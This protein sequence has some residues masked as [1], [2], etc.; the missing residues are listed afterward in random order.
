M[1]QFERSCR[2]FVKRHGEALFIA[3][4]LL[5]DCFLS[6]WALTVGTV[7]A[8][9]YVIIP[10]IRTLTT[11]DA[12]A[13]LTFL[14]AFVKTPKFQ[15]LAILLFWIYSIRALIAMA[16]DSALF[17]LGSEQTP[18]LTNALFLGAQQ[19]API[20]FLSS[21]VFV[22]A[23]AC[24]AAI[25]W[26]S[27][28][29]ATKEDPD[30]IRQR[31]VWSGVVQSGFF[32]SY[33]GS[34]LMISLNEKGP[35]FM[36][37]NWLLASARD[38]NLY[39]TV[40]ATPPGIEDPS[41]ITAGPGLM[42]VDIANKFGDLSFISSFDFLLITAFS[43][44]IFL[45]FLQPMLRLTSFMTSFCW[46]VVSPGSLQ[47]IVEGFLEA[48][49]LKERVLGFNEKRVFWGNAL[50]T[51]GWLVACYAGLFWLFGF[52]GGPLGL[53]IQNWM[54]ASGVDA[55]FLNDD[56][57]AKFLFDKNYRIFLG[58]IVA[59]Y[60]TAPLAVTAS[61]ILPYAKARKIT[62]N[63]DGISFFQGPY[64]SLWGRQTRLWSD[65]KS[66]KSV[67]SKT[68]QS[69]SNTAFSL[70]FRS[71][72]Q[73]KFDSSQIPAQDLR[74]L[75]DAI[76]QHA[77]ACTVDPEIFTVCQALEEI[78]KE[79]AASDGIDDHAIATIAKQEFKSTV[80]VPFSPGDFL[81]G[82]RTRI[83]KQ[84]ASK[85]LCAVYL[86]RD[87]EGKMQTVKQFYLADD[88]EETKAFAK[89]LR[90]EY[91]LLSKLDHPGIAKVSTSFTVDQST[92]LVIEHRPGTDLREIIKEHGA[93]SE[94]LTISWA[95]Q[96]CEIMMYLHSRE[97]AILHRDLTPDNIIAGEDGQLRLIDFGAARE[98]LE[99]I[100]GTMIGKQCYVAPEQLRGDAS[101][102][103]DI[104]S[105]GCTLYYALTGNDP[106]A[107]SQS[108]PAK[109][110]DCAEA[111]DKL[112]QDCTSFE[113]SERP[114]SFEEVLQ[115]L[116]KLDKGFR[117]KLSAQKEKVSV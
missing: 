61:V 8:V 72:G 49:R 101:K 59:L 62:L 81:P 40:D 89:I 27:R 67:K 58:S 13:Q 43:S 107:L 116:K 31:Q 92:Y 56:G 6:G 115:R 84:L 79:Q 71:G 48:L 55:G 110:L 69:N 9:L 91:E 75:L 113:E 35:A 100:T 76:D 22:Y 30:L 17:T 34:I 16:T 11:L 97:P 39:N 94:S 60:G 36:I 53:G 108:S 24:F 68:T 99:G 80:F 26:R 33:I 98:F 52:C 105:F 7:A 23:G 112:I 104:Y 86:A 37:S 12:K 54:I 66:L 73:I 96:I 103:S 5:A 4:F 32:L 21:P 83:I 111:L 42:Q 18:S 78:A 47:N 3:A 117:I 28:L 85:P 65:L 20:A 114:Q 82:T 41:W 70:V 10:V 38:A 15:K 87:A 63:C 88:T 1:N 2:K 102:K 45:L 25:L 95:E 46:R 74:V 19:F 93:R 109:D 50:R 14:K 90:R 29:K 57:A 64:M 106:K 44:F 77:V 51:L